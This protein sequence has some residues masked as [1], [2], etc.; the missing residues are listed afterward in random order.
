[1]QLCINHFPF[2]DAIH[3]KSERSPS[4]AIGLFTIPFSRSSFLFPRLP[5][6]RDFYAPRRRAN[7]YVCLIVKKKNK[8]AVHFPFQKQNERFFSSPCIL[9]P[10][11]KT[12]PFSSELLEQ[13]F[14]TPSPSHTRS[15]NM[16]NSL[17]FP[18]QTIKKKIKRNL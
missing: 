13:P 18:T 7:T 8:I 17:Y 10:P 4:D 1:M 3:P 11:R 2:S 16:P 15:F 14:S 5:F 12:C 9:Q 6:V